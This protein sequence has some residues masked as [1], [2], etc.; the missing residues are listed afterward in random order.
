MSEKVFVSAESLLQDS[1]EL[2]MRIVTHRRC[3]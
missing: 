3:V 1:M 2:A